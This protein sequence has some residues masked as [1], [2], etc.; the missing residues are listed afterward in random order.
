MT[1]RELARR[2]ESGILVRLLWDAATGQTLIRYRDRRTGDR[3]TATVPAPC[4]LEAFRHPNAYRSATL[5]A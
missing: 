3:F 2:N 1:I 4:A 5:S